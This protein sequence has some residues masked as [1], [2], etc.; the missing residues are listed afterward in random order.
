MKRRCLILA[1]ALFTG[2]ARGGQELTLGVLAVRPGPV[3]Q[4]RYQP[5]ADYLSSRLDN[6]TVRLE[7]LDHDR[8]QQAL[9]HNRLDLVLTNPS[10]Y[11]LL[12]RRNSL[13]GV[14]ATL[15]SEHDG[16]AT[17]HQGGVIITRSDRSTIRGLPDLR[18]R[19]V[20]VLGR[21]ALGGFQA[22]MLELLNA[23]LKMPRPEPARGSASKT[24]APA[25]N[26]VRLITVDTYDAVVAAV[27]DGR[28]D[29]GF[30]R[31]GILETLAAEGR[32]DPARLAVI[33]RQA[34][35]DFPYPVSTRLYP[36]WPLVALPQVDDDTARRL[37]AAVLSLD[38]GH[39]AARAAG[40][41][42]F[43]PPAD[44]LAVEN[45]IRTLRLPP[46]EQPP[47]LTW[48]ELRQ[49]H[50]PTLL[51]L[52][53]A[54]ACLL[55][56]LVL[57][58]SRN[59]AL[60]RSSQTLSMLVAQQRALLTAM[61]FP[62]FEI[63]GDGRTRRVWARS[64]LFTSID[65]HRMVGL[66]VQQ[67]LPAQT[68]T[69]VMAALAKAA[70][71]GLV[72]G[73]EVQVPNPDGARDIELSISAIDAAGADTRFLVLARDVT[74]ER[75]NQRWLNVAASVFT[76]AGEGILISDPN[77]RIL[78]VNKAFLRIIGYPDDADLVGR[79]THELRIDYLGSESFASLRQSLRET[80]QWQGELRG[81]RE[82]G[83]TYA[84]TLNINV[85]RDGD[86]RM[87][88]HIAVLT[89]V[90]QLKAQQR[91]LEHIA[92][93]DVLTGLPNRALLADRL[94]Q[95][96]AHADRLGSRVAVAYIDLDGFKAINDRHGHA[97]GDRLLVATSERMKKAIR[98]S[99]TLARL[100]G[101]EFVAVL[102]GLHEDGDCRP[103]I[104][105]LLAAAS[106]PLI[107]DDRVLR[108]TASVGVTLY[109]QAQ[110]P[111]A[112]QLL[113]QADH[114][115]YDAKQSGSNRFHVHDPAVTQPTVVQQQQARDM[116]VHRPPATG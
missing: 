1:L 82:D 49:R 28:A 47:T 112:D 38:A 15:R 102:T 55:G 110:A 39:P 40:I 44:Y 77:S 115:M 87:T 11:L 111:S 67:L 63:D 42:G 41:A 13:S 81:Q 31:T 72:R 6:V 75:E 20:A 18:G 116:A 26:T 95:A 51:A 78:A 45:L 107:I 17:T 106:A 79:H 113:R 32:L 88:H 7:V 50:W 22:P 68:A 10:S 30:V 37:T 62:V 76:F 94:Q 48:H 29:A 52:G 4:T 64:D 19:R 25:G 97:V 2:T 34:L 70:D 89:D 56:L 60:R 80:G 84:A 108:V 46:Y 105:R 58:G 27:L 103:M 12:R 83:S 99:D 24:S 43:A 23:G 33:N 35:A 96:M 65:P 74:V 92:Y 14:L 9:A 98:E 69:N 66:T 57:L 91:Q 86:G 93:H 90:S 100:G 101:D 3:T 5:L 59:R 73:L 53:I 21:W 85:A 61:P 109:P 16:R 54:A 36:E 104:E 71:C 114:A 8:L